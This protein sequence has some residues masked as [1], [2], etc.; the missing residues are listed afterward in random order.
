[1]LYAALMMIGGVTTV[2]AFRDDG[3]WW[4]GII[5]VICFILAYL[6]RPDDT[7]SVKKEPQPSPFDPSDLD[8]YDD[9]HEVSAMMGHRGGMAIRQNKSDS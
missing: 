3:V 8:G 1:M 9:S 2:Y 5:A 6:Q 7:K 4:L